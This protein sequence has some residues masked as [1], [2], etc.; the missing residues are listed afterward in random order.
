MEQIPIVS[1][2]FFSRNGHFRRPYSNVS[3]FSYPFPPRTA[4]AGLLGAI[5]GIN[6]EKVSETFSTEKSKIGISLNKQVETFTHVSNFRQTSSG[7]INYSIKI[8]KKSKKLKIPNCISDS[9]KVAIIPM[10]LL[11]NP[12]YLIYVSMDNFMDELISRL[13]AQRYVYTPCMGLSEFLAQIEYVSEGYAQ[14]LGAR[15]AE[16]STVINKDDCSLW[17]DK[18][19]SSNGYNIQELK[20]PHVSTPERTF[21][22]KTYLVNWTS[23][24]IPVKMK[25]SGYIFEDKVITFL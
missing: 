1:F 24:P 19:N 2:N 13:K 6:K 14:P 21:N 8:S 25:N 9:N 22:Y 3:S 4:I 23:N 15:E 16:V 17:I 10:E 18:I 20:V 12:S 7:D 11:K 5:L